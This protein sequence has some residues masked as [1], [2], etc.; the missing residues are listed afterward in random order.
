MARLMTQEA[1]DKLQA[2][3][4]AARRRTQSIDDGA[5][6]DTKRAIDQEV[7]Q[8]V[9][10]LGEYFASQLEES[11]AAQIAH[12]KL[13]EPKRQHPYL[14]GSRHT[15]DFAWPD[16]KIGVEV[17]GMAH[18]IK[19]RFKADVQKRAKGL[20]QGWRILEVGGDEVRNGDALKW[21]I[22]LIT[23]ARD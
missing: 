5:S 18:R 4:L 6:A 17:Q 12:H 13:P 1:Y 8:A 23:M 7:K 10:A 16:L 14:I 20:L 19:G 9:K 22:E 21:L 2:K 11:F 3:N 15:L